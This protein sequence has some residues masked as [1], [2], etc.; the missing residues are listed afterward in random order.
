MI[1]KDVLLLQS[2]LYKQITFKNGCKPVVHVHMWEGRT[3]EPVKEIITG[4]LMS[5]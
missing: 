2:V 3:D 1:E 5:L 4:I